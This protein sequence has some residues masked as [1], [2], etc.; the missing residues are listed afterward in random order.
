MIPDLRVLT[1]SL[2]LG[3]ILDSGILG[4]LGYVGTNG[5]CLVI[6]ILV[7]QDFVWLGPDASLMLL[8]TGQRESKKSFSIRGWY[9]SPMHRLRSWLVAVG[10][11]SVVICLKIIQLSARPY[12]LIFRVSPFPFFPHTN[13]TKMTDIDVENCESSFSYNSFKPKFQ[14]IGLSRAPVN[15]GKGPSLIVYSTW[16]G[17]VIAGWAL[18]VAFGRYQLWGVRIAS[19]F[20]EV[21]NQR[22]IWPSPDFVLIIRKDVIIVYVQVSNVKSLCRYLVL[23]FSVVRLICFNTVLSLFISAQRRI[24]TTL[25]SFPP[26]AI[27]LQTRHRQEE[28]FTLLLAGLLYTFVCAALPIL[29]FHQMSCVSPHAVLPVL[30]WCRFCGRK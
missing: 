3:C 10:P 2:S 28:S 25:P 18:I 17:A 27:Q 16:R 14:V 5:Q 7:W 6:P 29:H 19:G 30:V 8:S 1:R 11:T 20:G 23:S 9:L 26:S 12:L 4:I 24:S 13:G 21:H 15:K 22:C